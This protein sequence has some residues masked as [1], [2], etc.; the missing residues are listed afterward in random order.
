MIPWLWSRIFHD[1]VVLILTIS[2]S[3][4]PK[5]VIRWSHSRKF[6]DPVIS[7]TKF[8]WSG[9]LT[10]R[11]TTP[12]SGD[13][14]RQN[15]NSM[16]RWSLHLFFVTHLVFKSDPKVHWIS[17]YASMIF[18][19][20]VINRNSLFPH[21]YQILDFRHLGYLTKPLINVSFF[22]AAPTPNLRLAPGFKGGGCCSA[23]IIL[24]HKTH[25]A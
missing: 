13:F 9:D 23:W 18:C 11:N 2:W 16:I 12:W 15:Q 10:Q 7:L 24:Y 5:P 4:S 6:H 22:V 8:P 17:T 1:L 3:T 21:K 14:T 25:C 19:I 20:V